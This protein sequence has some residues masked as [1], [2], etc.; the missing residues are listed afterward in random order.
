MSFRPGCLLEDR[1]T[2]IGHLLAVKPLG[3]SFEWLDRRLRQDLRGLEDDEARIRKNEDSEDFQDDLESVQRRF[4]IGR[5]LLE[6]LPVMF[7]STAAE[8][9]CLSLA[10]LNGNDIIVNSN[11]DIIALHNWGY[12]STKPLW[13]TCQSPAFLYHFDQN[14]EPCDED[15]DEDY[16]TDMKNYEMYNE[17]NSMFIDKVGEMQPRWKEIFLA[18]KAE[19]EFEEAVM[20]LRHGYGSED[21]VWLPKLKNWLETRGSLDLSQPRVIE[22]Y[23]SRCFDINEWAGVETP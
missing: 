7:S 5:Q 22:G 18:A 4:H 15:K 3:N 10:H 19:R 17:Y 2:Y 23:S 13:F 11:G 6:L 16:W 9:T 8:T 12:T 20:D 1:Q 21:L 14:F